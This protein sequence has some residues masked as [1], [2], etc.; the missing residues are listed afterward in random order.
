MRSHRRAPAVLRDGAHS[1]PGD[2]LLLPRSSPGSSRP[3]GVAG[4]SPYDLRGQTLPE[5]ARIIRNDEP[6][7]LSSIDSRFRGDV[8]TIVAKAMEKDKTR[9][10]AS[11]AALADDI[12]R[13]LSDEPLI[14]RPAST[15]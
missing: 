3:P 2:R 12:R 4:K 9:R 8:E 7:R 1:R 5:A 14:A 13:Y 6:S 15:F 10:Y 11:A